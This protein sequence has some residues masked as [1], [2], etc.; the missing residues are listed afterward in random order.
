MEEEA[1]LTFFS[2]ISTSCS[3]RKVQRNEHRKEVQRPEMEWSGAA[4]LGEFTH[5]VDES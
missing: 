5:L 2:L 3:W 4:W 1:L